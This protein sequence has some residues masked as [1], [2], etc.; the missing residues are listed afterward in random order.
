MSRRLVLTPG[1]QRAYRRFAKK[2]PNH[3]QRLDE[4]LSQMQEDVFASSLATHKL[5]GNLRHFWASAC[6]Y[7][8]RIVFSLKIDP[9]TGQEIL[10]LINIG[11][12]DEVY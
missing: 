5:S 9:D 11:T 6:G 3:R 12:H 2:N 4:V 8:C 10:F 1:F 7:D